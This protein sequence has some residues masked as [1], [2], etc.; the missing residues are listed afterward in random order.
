[1]LTL[2]GYGLTLRFVLSCHSFTL[3][4]MSA[5]IS[6]PCCFHC[7]CCCCCCCSRTLL[8]CT[9]FAQSLSGLE[10]LDSLNPLLNLFA[11]SVLALPF[12]RTF[13]QLCICANNLASQLRRQKQQHQ[14]NQDQEQDQRPAAWTIVDLLQIR[15]LC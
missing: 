14:Q 7:C 2:G 4:C 9:K 11:P 12:V 8:I 1:M 10:V 5:G 6:C 13:C 3:F 15:D